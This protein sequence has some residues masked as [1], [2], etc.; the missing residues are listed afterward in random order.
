LI[1]PEQLAEALDRIHP[2]DRELLSLSLRRRVPDEALGRLYECS[3]SEVARRRAR[4]IERLADEMDLQR[5]EDLGAVLQALLEPSTWSQ[6]T[7]GEEFAA[8]GGRSRLAAV[9]E[10]ERETEP[11]PEPPVL[12][13][14]PA[15]ALDEDPPEIA[16]AQDAAAEAP[17]EAPVAAAATESATE[18]EPAT[19]AAEAAPDP[20]QEMVAEREREA[21]DPPRR[22][23]PMALM[24][25]GVAALVG[26]AGVIGATQFGDKER[27]VPRGGD[28]GGSGTQQFVP[29]KGGALAAPFPTEPDKSSCYTTATVHGGA[30]LYRDP[31]GEKRL[32]IGPKTEWGSERVMGVVSQR[33]DWLGIQASEL[34]NGEI[35]WIQ[36]DRVTL[37][38]VQWSL[39]ADLSKRSVTVQHDGKTVRRLHVAIGRPENPTPKGRFSVTDRL[40][41]KGGDPTY[42]CCVLA[43]TGHQTHLPPYWPGGDRLAIHAT[44]DE[45]SIDHAVS[46]GCMRAPATQARWL[47]DHIPLGTPVFIHS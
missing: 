33:G 35:A 25:L 39:H 41:V 29:R 11:E 20:I 34:K 26:A 24:G 9:P 12:A 28:G 44:N 7:V 23:V 47:I 31:G 10:P 8:S 1:R 21:P 46:L 16:L 37:D 6:I 14:V 38:C 36:R 15:P 27:M 4:A 45:S 42:G 30:T 13:P 5:G 43:L 17:E 40:A 3:P 18:A 19:P 32:R 2:R 22:A